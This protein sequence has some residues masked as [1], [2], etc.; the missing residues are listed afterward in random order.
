MT[1]TQA[2]DLVAMCT[3]A[4][5]FFFFRVPESVLQQGVCNVIVSKGSGLASHTVSTQDRCHML[6]TTS[7]CSHLAKKKTLRFSMD[8]FIK[9]PPL[10]GHRKINMVIKMFLFLGKSALKMPEGLNLAVWWEPNLA[11]Q[12]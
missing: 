8:I 11:C 3:V 4:I 5:S 12:E 1:G 2:R 10:P 7:M 9:R 6:L